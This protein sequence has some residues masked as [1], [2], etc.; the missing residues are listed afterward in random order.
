[1]SVTDTDFV[2]DLLS[3]TSKDEVSITLSAS[4]L[5]TEMSKKQSGGGKPSMSEIDKNLKKMRYRLVSD[6]EYSAL[7]KVSQISQSTQKSFET[8]EIETQKGGVYSI[9]SDDS[10]TIVSLDNISS[11]CS[12]ILQQLSETSIYNELGLSESETNKDK[13]ITDS[14]FLSETSEFF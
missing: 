9:T 13:T 2:T 5:D 1:M 8:S 3:E 12:N 4:I 10:L 14:N 11:N 7:S 6:D